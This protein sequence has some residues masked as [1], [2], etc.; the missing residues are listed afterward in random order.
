MSDNQPDLQTLR[1]RENKWRVQ[2]EKALEALA[3]CEVLNDETGMQRLCAVFERTGGLESPA[4][5]SKLSAIFNNVSAPAEK[6]VLRLHALS[7]LNNTDWSRATY[8]FLSPPSERAEQEEPA[9]PMPVAHMITALTGS[10]AEAHHTASQALFTIGCRPVCGIIAVE[11]FNAVAENIS[12]PSPLRKD[13]ARN[14]ELL[15]NMQLTRLQG[16]VTELETTPYY[17]RPRLHAS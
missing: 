9:F 13:A 14:A 8:N 10:N 11:I 4:I 16:L 7:C 2:E 15:Q 5:H 1:R 17:P 12:L 3:W 6:D